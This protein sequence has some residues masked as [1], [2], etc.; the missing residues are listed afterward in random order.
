MIAMPIITA[1]KIA[2][3]TVTAS[4][5]ALKKFGLDFA[6][7]LFFDLVRRDDFVVPFVITAKLAKILDK[8]SK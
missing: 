2:P 5:W 8:S 3:A 1:A 7:D 6:A 4:E